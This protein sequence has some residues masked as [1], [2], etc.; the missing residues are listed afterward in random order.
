VQQTVKELI[1]KEWGIKAEP[2]INLS[3]KIVTVYV[4]SGLGISYKAQGLVEEF[5]QATGWKLVVKMTS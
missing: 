1:P 3:E 4:K 2:S 5:Y